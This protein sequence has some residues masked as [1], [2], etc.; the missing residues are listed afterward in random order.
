MGAEISTLSLYSNGMSEQEFLN[1]MAFTMGSM[2]LILLAAY[3]IVNK[4]IPDEEE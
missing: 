2:L 4:V 3:Y 1:Y